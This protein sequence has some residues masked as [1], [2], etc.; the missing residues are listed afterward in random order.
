MQR[1]MEELGYKMARTVIDNFCRKYGGENLN[2]LIVRKLTEQWLD[3]N[4]HWLIVEKSTR[5][6]NLAMVASPP[7][8]KTGMYNI[9]VGFE[10]N[11]QL[12]QTEAN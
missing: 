5:T 2:F 9:V 10:I 8:R 4:G 12:V 11:G 1:P 6:R 3:W 7:S